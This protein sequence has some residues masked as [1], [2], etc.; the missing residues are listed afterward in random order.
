M[1]A[2]PYCKGNTKPPHGGCRLCS[3][4]GQVHPPKHNKYCSSHE[5]RRAT[6]SF[7][8]THR[9]SATEI[10]TTAVSAC[11]ECLENYRQEMAEQEVARR[12]K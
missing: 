9:I 4:S 10:Q 11:D 12:G 3:G 7:P 8:V 1:S 5:Y 2:C 6:G